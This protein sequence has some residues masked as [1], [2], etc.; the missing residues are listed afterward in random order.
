MKKI[1]KTKRQKVKKKN[2]KMKDVIAEHEAILFS[3]G[4]HIMG[5]VVVDK[6]GKII[7]INKGFETLTDWKEKEVLGKSLVEV[8]PREDED[9]KR[10][11]FK[12]RIL[13]KILSGKILTSTEASPPPAVGIPIEKMPVFYYVRK[14]KSRFPATSVISPMISKGK[15]TGA[16]EVFYD[17]SKEKE[18]ERIRLD[19]LSL[20]SH[21]LRTPLSGVKWLIETMHGGILGEPT[22]KQK[23]YLNDIYK[24]NEQMIKLVSDILNTLRLESE[25]TIIKKETSR[26]QRLLNDILITVAAAAKEKK[27]TLQGPLNH[28]LLTIETDPVI[29]KSIIGTFLSNAIDYSMP[30]QKVLL[31]VKERA[32]TVTF[33]VQDF[34]IGIPKR[35]Q[36]RM[37]ERFY[38]ASNA[39]NLKPNGT[40]LGLN[41]ARTIAEKI[42]ANI[43][44]TSEENKGSTFYLRIPKTMSEGAKARNMHLN[45]H[46]K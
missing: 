28:R 32:G 33:L 19:F 41:I 37:F 17:I 25:A 15:I 31:D 38:R 46:S 3:V 30:G 39:K 26:V 34:G 40:G 45:K 23:E 35:E 14:D 43:S 7:R 4:D 22:K 16:V 9:K 13:S 8:L 42:G 12:D 18:L 5:V 24:V 21:Q 44:F 6:H 27:I 10:V 1:N 36:K 29:V 11:S 20:A 2:S